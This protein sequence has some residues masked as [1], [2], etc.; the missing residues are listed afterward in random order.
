MKVVESCAVPWYIVHTWIVAHPSCCCCSALFL[1]LL[2]LR[3]RYLDAYMFHLI[4]EGPNWF[5][6]LEVN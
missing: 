5:E 2:G 1:F 4:I 3:I 6:V